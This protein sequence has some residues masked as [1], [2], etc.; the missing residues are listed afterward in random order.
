M[1]V[2]QKYLNGYKVRPL[3]GLGSL[4]ERYG[5]RAAND[6]QTPEALFGFRGLGCR[7][8]GLHGFSV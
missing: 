6:L 8:F 5:C 3:F 1:V 7:G 4:W 2:V